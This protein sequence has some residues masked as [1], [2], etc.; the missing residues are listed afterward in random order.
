[1]AKIVILGAGIAGHTAAL[2]ATR[3]LGKKHEI[4]VVSPNSKYNWIPSNIWV[5]VGKMKSSQVI[6]PLAPVYKRKG[7]KFIQALATSIHPEGDSNSPRP[8]VEA[9]Q[10]SKESGGA[11][12]RIEYDYLINATGP[13]LNFSATPG[14]GPTANSV[15]VCTFDHAHEASE[16]LKS[17]IALLKQGKRQTLVVGV[18]HGTC[19]CE[20]AAFEYVFNVDHELRSAGVRD[21]ADLIYITNEHELGDFGVGGMVFSHK[22]SEVTSKTWTESLFH[23]RG[24]KAVLSAHVE[25]VDPGTIHYELVDGTREL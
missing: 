18:G 8:F 15:S 5:G 9:K 19:T 4:T 14:L 13:K 16:K 10:T 17:V 21:L 24:V 22:G 7:I 25:R 20:G 1:M 3:I 12:T 6:F 23:E 11:V 2:H